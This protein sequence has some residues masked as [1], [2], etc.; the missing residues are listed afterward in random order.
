M[1]QP[2]LH[3]GAAVRVPAWPALFA[4]N[5]PR[6]RATAWVEVMPFGLS[7]TTQPCTGEPLRLRDIVILGRV[8]TRMQVARHPLG[9]QNCLDALCLG[10][11]GVFDEPQ[12]RREF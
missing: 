10:K 1:S 9:M 12:F 4:S 5:S 3:L 6:T 7:N 8:A 2:P 11:G